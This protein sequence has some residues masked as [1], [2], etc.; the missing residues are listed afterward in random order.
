MRAVGASS[1]D[2]MQITV[3]EGV[4]IGWLSWFLAGLIAFPL[5]QAL[6]YRIGMAFFNAPLMFTYSFPGL[7][8]WFGVVTLISIFASIVPSQNAMRITVREAISYE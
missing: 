5:G 8:I 6:S 1:G 2:L 7:G 4:I 3:T